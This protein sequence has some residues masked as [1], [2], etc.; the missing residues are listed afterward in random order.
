MSDGGAVVGASDGG[1][2]VGSV[3][4]GVGGAVGGGVAIGLLVGFNVGRGVG[5][6][7][8]RWVGLRKKKLKK[9][10]AEVPAAERLKTRR[11]LWYFIVQICEGQIVKLQV[12]GPKLI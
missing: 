3:G 9:L 5:R 11:R 6:R 7:V 10:W 2:V 8:G 4:G 12:P 1:A